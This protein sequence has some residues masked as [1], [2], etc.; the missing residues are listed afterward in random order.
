MYSNNL[1]V[2]WLCKRML[3]KN[4][5][6]IYIYQYNLL[7]KAESSIYYYCNNNTTFHNDIQDEKYVKQYRF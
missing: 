2:I 7:I 5:L 4:I 6:Y 1:T 3:T